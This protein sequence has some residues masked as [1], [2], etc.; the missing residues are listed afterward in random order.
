MLKEV[1]SWGKLGG[2]KPHEFT[3]SQPGCCFEASQFTGWSWEAEQSQFL[4]LSS[5]PPPDAALHLCAAVVLQCPITAASKCQSQINWINVWLK[6]FRHTDS[7]P[8]LRLG[9]LKLRE[10]KKKN[11]C[12]KSAF[13]F[14]LKESVSHSLISA[15]GKFCI[16]C[17]PIMKDA[18]KQKCTRLHTTDYYTVRNCK[19][20]Q[21][22]CSW[23]HC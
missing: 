2:N 12:H 11:E 17:Y 4:L 19:H 10:R 14:T 7:F 8:S 22:V 15:T 3:G 18:S 23:E 6:V 16:L 21:A 1:R 5:P 9:H 20:Y 13:Q